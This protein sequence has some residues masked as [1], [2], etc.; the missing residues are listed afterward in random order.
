MWDRQPW[1]CFVKYPSKVLRKCRILSCSIL[2]ACIASFLQLCPTIC[3]PWAVAQQACLSIGFFR[4]EH[5]SR[6]PCPPAGDLSYPGIEPTSPAAAALQANANW[7]IRG[8]FTNWVIREVVYSFYAPQINN[9]AF[10]HC[11]ISCFMSIYYD[12]LFWLL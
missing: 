11:R 7:V 5:W 9:C 12:F 3:N 4:Q 6:L 8:H 10:C 1:G 2:S